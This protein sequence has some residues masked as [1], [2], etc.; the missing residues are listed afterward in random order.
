MFHDK[1]ESALR[2]VKNIDQTNVMV[3]GA[4]TKGLQAAG[5]RIG[6]VIASRKNVEILGNFGTTITGG[7]SHLSQLYAI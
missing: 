6:W 1:P 4:A 7:V 5:I 2:Y 3:L